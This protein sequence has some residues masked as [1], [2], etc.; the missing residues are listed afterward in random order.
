M[1]SIP[2]YI[3]AQ[4]KDIIYAN[5][6]ISG[7]A[8][9][10]VNNQNIQIKQE[11]NYPWEG[12]LKFTIQTEQAIPF[13]FQIRIPGWASNHAI[14]NNLYHFSNHSNSTV[15]IT[16]NG[17]PAE[18]QIQNGFAIIKR[19]WNKNDQIQVELPMETRRVESDS[20]IK[21]NI[22]KSSIQRGPLMY[23]AE[24]I[25]NAGNTSNIILPK[26]ATFSS[27]FNANL[28]NGITV[29]KSKASQIEISSDG[30]EIKTQSKP[31]T[32]IPYYAW[33]NRGKGEMTVWIPEKITATEIITK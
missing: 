10:Q 3:Y 11:N 5:L 32:A 15:T 31:F 14:P 30:L 8:S 9:L 27:S 25:D 6:F 20:L 16:V 18:Y 21:D 4:N 23:C 24:W 12:N 22:G 2:G 33:A 13:S 1:P 29:L 19:V 28:L 7:T 26:S 17:K